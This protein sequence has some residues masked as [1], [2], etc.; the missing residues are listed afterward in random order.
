M[1]VLIT[2]ITPKSIAEKKRIKINDKIVSINGNEINDVLDYDYYSANEKLSIV[3]IKE[4]GKQKTIHI[5]KSE[6]EDIGVQF[7]TY[8]MDKQ[9]SCTNKCIFCFVD[10]LPCGM[11]ESLYF[12][13]D[14][15]RLSFLF[16]NYITLT[17]MKQEE[18]ERIIKM[19]ISPINISVHTTNP[20]LRV[21][22]MKNRFA[23][24]VLKYIDMLAKANIKLN[25]QLV[26]CRGINDGEE[27]KRSLNDLAKLYPSVQS[28]A[29]V[30]VG[31]TKYRENLPELQTY[32]EKAAGETIDLIE[33]FNETFMKEHGTRIAYPADEFFIKANRPIP[34]AEYYEDF[35]QLDNGVGVIALQRQEFQSALEELEESDLVRKITIA[36]GIDARPFLQD[37]VCKLQKKWRNFECDVVAIENEFFGKTITVAGL[38]TGN[39]LIRQLKEKD[40]GEALLLPACMLRHEQDLFLDDVSLEQVSNALNIPIVLSENNGYE[41]LDA[42]I[43]KKEP[44]I[45]NSNS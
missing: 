13:D 28:I 42:L 33:S 38:V 45:T 34:D 8:L 21:K 36:T 26:L 6:Y 37:L 12:K 39:D 40:L 11:R 41:F 7:S 22:M 29:C 30:P 1:S 14:D 20:E 17:N 18:I 19:H 44:V 2:G 43:G 24:E 16:G 35:A 9:H 10:Q 27:L 31:I 4:N 3:V 5:K 25:T 23:G 15:E 32:D